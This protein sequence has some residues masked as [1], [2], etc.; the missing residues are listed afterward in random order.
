MAKLKELEKLKREYLG[1]D[2]ANEEECLE[3]IIEQKQNSSI[4]YMVQTE[5]ICLTAIEADRLTID[6]VR[7][8]TPEICMA[9]VKV[10]PWALQFV[11]EQ[12]PEICMEAIKRDGTM[13]RYVRK[14]TPEICMAAVKQNAHALRY[15]INQTEKLCLVAVDNFPTAFKYVQ[16]QTEAICAVYL[17]RLSEELHC[18]LKSYFLADIEDLNMVKDYIKFIPADVNK[19]ND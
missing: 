2:P 4:A 1:F 12:T 16:N 9:A 7:K 11:R 3:A 5:K 17:K 15:V 6:C 19:D 10:N 14:Q 18:G 8:Q 13:L